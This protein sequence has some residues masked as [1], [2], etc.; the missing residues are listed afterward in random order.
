M[1]LEGKSALITG[2][3]SGI[4]KATALRFAQ[5]G[6]AVMCADIDADGAAATAD[7]IKAD[8]GRAASMT[9]DVTDEAA[10]KAALTGTAD[11]LGGLDI[12]F[13]NAGIGGS[14]GWDTTIAVNLSGVYYGLFHGAT[15]LAER[16]GGVV[17]STASIAGLV[18]LSGPERGNNEPLAPGAGAY[19]AAK[20]GVSGLTRQYAVTFGRQGVRVNAVA[21]GYIE[22]PMTA[23]IRESEEFEDYIR[24]L[25][26]AGRFGQPE[27]IASVVAFLASDDASFINGVVLPVDGGYTAR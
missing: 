27:E 14:Q 7:A 24:S 10:V 26:P 18:G 4:G 3:A 13:N 25:H 5:D 12:I 11:A 15:F 17:I 23:P 8:G 20:H 2:A 21:P 6:A 22:T 9:L 1:G 19:V 16:G